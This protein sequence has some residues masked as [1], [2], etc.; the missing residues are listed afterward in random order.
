M[1]A[2][3]PPTPPT[4][5]AAVVAA[6]ALLRAHFDRLHVVHEC[7]ADCADDCDR[8]DYSGSA[9]RYHD[10][11]NADVREE[12]EGSASG[13]V[14]A[15]EGWLG[16]EALTGPRGRCAEM[17]T[18]T[19]HATTAPAADG[20]ASKTVVISWVEECHHGITVRVPVDFDPEECDLANGL[21]AL[22]PDGYQWCQRLHID[23]VDADGPDPGAQ[24]FSPPRYDDEVSG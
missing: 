18:P 8:S 2:P 21:A 24:Y 7:D 17:T 23:V 12:I 19:Q 5:P 20:L 1:S 16:A 15:L 22:D 11:H 14:A 9:Y 4:P 10:E 3:T 13:L 6:V